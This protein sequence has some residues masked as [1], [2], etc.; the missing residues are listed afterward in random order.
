MTYRN[1][2]NR[3]GWKR[4]AIRNI[5]SAGTDAL[6]VSSRTA[7]R[8]VAGVIRQFK[9]PAKHEGI[10]Q[11]GLGLRLQFLLIDLV[12]AL[13]SATLMF[14]MVAFGLPLLIDGMTHSLRV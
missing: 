4:Q 9:T 10:H 2:N 14:I 12:A 7:D 5:Q 8:T 13:V 11:L 3:L 6:Y 1:H